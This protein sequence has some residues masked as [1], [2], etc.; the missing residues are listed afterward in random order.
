MTL[1]NDFNTLITEM[2]DNLQAMGVLDAEFDSSTGLRGLSARILDIEPSVSGLNLET[3]LT[4]QSETEKRVGESV[5]ISPKLNVFYDD[6]T[7]VNV[8]LS[9]VLTGATINI[10][11]GNNIIGTGITNS[12]GIA[13]ISLSNLSLGTHNLKAV[14]TG[15]ENFQE[16]ESN[17]IT[18]NVVVLKPTN[19]DITATKNIL[20]YTDAD[21]TDITVTL[22]DENDTPVSGQTVT[23]EVYMEGDDN[24]LETLSVVDENDGTYT[25]TYTSQGV[26]DIYVKAEC[27]SLVTE[28]Y[29]VE[30][31]IRYDSTDYVN[32]DAVKNWDLPSQFKLSFKILSDSWSGSSGSMNVALIR[33]NSSTGVWCG[34]GSSSSRTIYA[35]NGVTLTSIP[36]NVETE[37]TLTYDNGNCS[38]TDGTSTVTTTA[39]LTKLYMIAAQES[40]HAHLKNIKIKPL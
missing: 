31:C 22:L 21:S 37:Y 39:S 7:L 6:E 35:P 24:L 30:D 14:F 26:G 19:I 28:T 10:K 1:E 34:K 17:T 8:D 13:D 20:S 18:I 27:S 3:S 16:C 25:S 40:N 32:V 38:F 36:A 11:E 2:E 12:N 9:G 33:F 4:V 15:T 23:M 29:T 5:V